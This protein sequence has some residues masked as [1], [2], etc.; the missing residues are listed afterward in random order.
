M[1][2]FLRAHAHSSSYLRRKSNVVGSGVGLKLTQ[3]QP[4]SQVAVLVFVRKKEPLGN[5]AH[6]ERVESH[7][8]G[9]P[10][11][12][13]EVGDVR[14]LEFSGKDHPV[15]PQGPSSGDPTRLRKV[16]PAP[17]GVSLGHYLVTAGTF[18]AVVERQGVRYILSNNHVLANASNG[19]DGRARRGD[20]ILQPGTYDGGVT[21]ADTIAR[22]VEFA[23]LLSVNDPVSLSPLL[24]GL[25]RILAAFGLRL[26]SNEV[27]VN[28]VDAALAA[29]V[30]PDDISPE[31]LG[32][33]RVTGVARPNLGERVFKSGRSSGVTSGRLLG[34][35]VRMEVGYGEQSAEFEHQF[36][37]SRLSEPGDSGALIV[38]ERR[39]AVALLFAGSDKATLGNPIQ[40]VMDALK[41][42][43]V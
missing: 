19:R 33:G 41:V 34:L 18:G 39:E 40:T 8:D 25:Q 29:P 23:P 17:P 42:Q 37:F 24:R 21:G 27:P 22:L 26:A 15:T 3:G 16:R 13:V 1:A 35:D 2:Q 6:S 5:L 38:N 28:T 12:V 32:I 11:D 14:L 36:L 43:L 20:A 7:I 30:N 4:T 9:M 31:I 10:T